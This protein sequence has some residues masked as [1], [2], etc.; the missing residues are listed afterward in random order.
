LKKYKLPG[1]DH[2]PRKIIQ[3]EGKKK[4]KQNMFRDSQI[5]DDVLS[6]YQPGQMVVL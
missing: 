2:I 5:Y 1:T 6:V 4:K 3:A